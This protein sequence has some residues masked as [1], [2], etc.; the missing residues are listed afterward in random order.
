MP[1]PPG[2]ARLQTLW[3]AALGRGPPLVGPRLLHDRVDDLEAL[4]GYRLKRLVVPHPPR[5]ACGD[6]DAAQD[7]PFQLPPA[8]E[9]EVDGLEPLGDRP[10]A[11]RPRLRDGLPEQGRDGRVERIRQRDEHVGVGNREP[12]LPF[13]DRL[14][15]HVQS[16]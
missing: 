14:P 8:R 11:V 5:R 13:R 15:Y 9:L 3:A 1:C 2:R 12:A 10:Q 4:A 7:L 6:E 16:Y